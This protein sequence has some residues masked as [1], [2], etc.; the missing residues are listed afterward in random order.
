MV[1][2][3][4]DS[5]AL[6]PSSSSV[7]L[8]A[9]EPQRHPTEPRS[10][11]S[12]D[13]F[14]FLH[15]ITG[16]IS[17]SY[18]ARLFTPV[19]LV[20]ISAFLLVPQIVLYNS[21]SLLQRID[22]ACFAGMEYLGD[23]T[24][25]AKHFIFTGLALNHRTCYACL[26]SQNVRRLRS[27]GRTSLRR[28]SQSHTSSIFRRMSSYIDEDVGSALRR[29][30][31]SYEGLVD[32]VLPPAYTFVSKKGKE[33]SE[34]KTE[35][36]KDLSLLKSKT[37]SLKGEEQKAEQSRTSS[38]SR[39]SA[40]NIPTLEH[41]QASDVAVRA[42]DS[43]ASTSAG[44]V[45]STSRNPLRK[46]PELWV[47]TR[48]SSNGSTI[49][50]APTSQ[51]TISDYLTIT[52]LDEMPRLRRQSHTGIEVSRLVM[53]SSTAASRLHSRWMHPYDTFARMAKEREQRE[54]AAYAEAFE[55]EPV[56]AGVNHHEQRD[57]KVVFEKAMHWV[58]K[59]EE[60]IRKV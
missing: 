48:G 43:V 58:H 31:N 12:T 36:D 20:L 37:T 32:T 26:I 57:R 23:A 19:C 45:G 11:R 6:S 16:L 17:K 30:A 60:K 8:S 25:R 55:L 54:P 52:T 41:I 40:P 13:R 56:A 39:N 14:P 50:N 53:I 7:F 24:R 33:N 42:S 4:G 9:Q 1:Q 10:S 5:P 38:I 3:L 2:R 28:T 46:S 29:V 35:K 22:K 51:P 15:F 44:D 18:G 21:L 34:E 49:T 47:P 59:Q 27:I